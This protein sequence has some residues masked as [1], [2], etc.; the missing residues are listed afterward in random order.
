MC[1]MDAIYTFLYIA[2]ISAISTELA[3]GQVSVKGWELLPASNALKNCLKQNTSGN[4]T[5]SSVMVS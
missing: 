3:S 1:H 2:T 5:T 4:V